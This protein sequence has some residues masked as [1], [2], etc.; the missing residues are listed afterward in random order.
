MVNNVADI[1]L[2]KPRRARLKRLRKFRVPVAGIIVIALLLNVF[3][4]W[5]RSP[6]DLGIGNRLVTSGVLASWRNGDLI[7][8]VR[9]E[10][11]C[12]RSGNPCYGPAD[13]LTVNGTQ[14]AA[15][16]GSAFESLGMER[17][18]VL[19]SPTTRTA[20]TSLFM[21][22]K[23]E[24]SPGPLA[25]CGDAMG[26]EILSHKQ[27][28]RNLMLITHSACMSDFQEALGYPHA[29]AAEYGSALF[30][31]VLPD[32]KLKALGTMKRQEW[33]AALKQL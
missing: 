5:P 20:Q 4:F 32:G 19:S 12:D 6:Q 21:F 27:A 11:R 3:I 23:T 18:D 26:E 15:D 1:T 17:T 22:G 29:Q 14:R 10:E 24:L 16:L 2:T 28:D 31:Q 7:V 9:H 33:A 8:L 25:I 13:G 30:V